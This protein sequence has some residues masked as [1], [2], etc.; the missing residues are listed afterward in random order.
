MAPAIALSL[1]MKMPWAPIQMGAE[2]P[3]N[4]LVGVYQTADGRC[5]SLVM[6]QGF[7]YW[8][9]FCEHID[10]PELADDPRFNSHENLMANGEE[11]RAYIREAIGSGTLAEWT[12]R[13]RSMKGQWAPVQN[14]L[15]VAA[16]R[17]VTANGYL[18]RTA[19]M[20]GVEFDLVASPVQFDEQPTG[21]QRA[22]E[23]N[24]HGDEILQQLG[25]DWDTIIAMKAAGAVT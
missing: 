21:T 2:G 19:T 18:A 25:Y 11:A 13:F 3:G 8:R 7:F 17:Q 5:I 20:H 24:E 16:D 4:P 23:F 6:L 9:D 12:E 14:T 15:E 22:P 1:Q 10:K